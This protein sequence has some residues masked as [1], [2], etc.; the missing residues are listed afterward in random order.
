M[1]LKKSAVLFAASLAVANSHAETDMEQ[2]TVYES[3]F[4]FE[5]MNL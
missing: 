4:G 2:V 3:S 5:L 1:K